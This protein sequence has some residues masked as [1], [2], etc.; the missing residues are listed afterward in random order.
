VS[1]GRFLHAA[2]SVVRN[3]AHTATI[4]ARQVAQTGV[5]GPASKSLQSTK[6]EV[7]PLCVWCYDK[8]EIQVACPR[9][10]TYVPGAIQGQFVQDV[11]LEKPQNMDSVMTIPALRTISWLPTISW[12]H[13]AYMYGFFHDS[14]R[15]MIDSHALLC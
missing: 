10:V 14:R 9:G 13:R 4:F 11:V 7:L 15:R 6:I 8:G 3:S 1:H 2:T 12:L 5:C